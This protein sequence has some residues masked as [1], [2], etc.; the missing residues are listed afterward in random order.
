MER[1]E[2]SINEHS[3]LKNEI[4]FAAESI[5]DQEQVDIMTRKVTLQR[6]QSDRKIEPIETTIGKNSNNILFS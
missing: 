3:Y 4:N 5:H 6:K 2:E 1:D